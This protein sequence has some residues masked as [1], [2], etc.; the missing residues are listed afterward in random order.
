M[1]HVYI[2][3]YKSNHSQISSVVRQTLVRASHAQC[4]GASCVLGGESIYISFVLTVN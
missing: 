1:M 2:H 3:K 4:H